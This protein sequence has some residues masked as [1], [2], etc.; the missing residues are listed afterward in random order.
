[1]RVW[2][3]LF[4]D[5]PQIMDIFEDVARVSLHLESEE[6]R[7]DGHVYTDVVFSSNVINS[8]MWRLLEIQPRSATELE[9]PHGV[10]KEATRLGLLLFLAEAR[11]RFGLHPVNTTIHVEMLRDVLMREKTDWSGLGD[12]R[13]WIV[14]MGVLE[15]VEEP[16]L[17]W[18]VHEWTRTT[19]IE[20]MT[21][22]ARME[23]AV[24]DVMWI[25]TV[26]GKKYR[27]LLERFWGRVS[28][29]NF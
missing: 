11:R 28:V 25:D 12:L 24:R 9:A 19:I 5:Q 29:Q 10:L 4:P 18:F 8:L 15:A 22:P 13:L 23:R 20:Q 17:K 27:E 3:A 2:R 1:M 21:V 16:C 7:T 6:R 14:A 26:H